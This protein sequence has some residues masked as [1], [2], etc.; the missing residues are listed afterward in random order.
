MDALG[1]AAAF[2]EGQLPLEGQATAYLNSRGLRQRICHDLG[3]GW[4]PANGRLLVDHLADHG[5][6]VQAMLDAGL[7]TVKE[8]HVPY[9]FFRSRVSFA[10]RNRNGEVIGFGARSIDGSEPKYLNTRETPIFDKG[11]ILFNLDRA[12]R[13]IAERGVAIVME[14]YIDVATVAQEGIRNVVAPLGTALTP[15]QLHALWRVAPHIV[16]FADGD[17]AGLRASARTLETALPWIAG[18]RR[19]SVAYAPAGL[20]P[21]DIVRASGKEAFLDI[22]RNAEDFASALW[23]ALREETPGDRPEDRARL[24]S[25]IRERVGLVGD[26]P[27]RK[28]MLANLLRRSGSVG[29]DPKASG[30]QRHAAA[31]G[32]DSGP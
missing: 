28:A 29:F 30:G 10:I 6:S 13:D 21:D 27:M 32:R 20:D 24:E 19:L 31:H 22:V 8:N 3:V 5:F 14:G 23:R 12:R 18:D 9:S 1:A 17:P 4:A 11:S 15:E 16:Y 7:V 2:F 26:E 25:L